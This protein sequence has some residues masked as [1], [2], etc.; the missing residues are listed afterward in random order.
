[1]SQA[2]TDPVIA[3][4]DGATAEAEDRCVQGMDDEQGEGISL[5]EKEKKQ[6]LAYWQKVARQAVLM[7]ER[8]GI[9]EK[10]STEIRVHGPIEGDGYIATK[11]HMVSFRLSNG[12]ACALLEVL[13][14]DDENTHITDRR[15]MVLN[16]ET[17]KIDDQDYWF[18]VIPG[19]L[20]SCL[21]EAELRDIAH[22]R[23]A[24]KES[25]NPEKGL[26][27]AHIKAWQR[28]QAGRCVGVKDQLLQVAEVFG[29]NADVIA[30]E[31]Q[32]YRD[33]TPEKYWVPQV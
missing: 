13:F 22:Q 1:M 25:S 31:L 19:D 14:C 15:A 24:K 21:R 28:A 18:Q 6:R 7:A 32:S 17:G 27:R 23:A 12:R 33:S 2:E 10:G 4:S 8:D 30:K 26:M 3:I 11:K 9:P 5:L 16:P 20:I 29:L